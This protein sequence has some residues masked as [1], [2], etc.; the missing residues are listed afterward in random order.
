MGASDCTRPQVDDL[1]D[2]MYVKME[3]GGGVQGSGGVHLSENYGIPVIQKSCSV[4][5]PVLYQ[6]DNHHQRRVFFNPIAERLPR[7]NWNIGG[8][9]PMEIVVSTHLDW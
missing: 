3:G 2:Q 1:A 9:S 5:Y 4:D 7:L 6:Q 8:N